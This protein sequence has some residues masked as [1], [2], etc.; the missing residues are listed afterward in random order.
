MQRVQRFGLNGGAREAV[1]DDAPGH[2]RCVAKAVAKDGKD[3]L[4]ADQDSPG[5]HDGLRGF[6]SLGARGHGAS[7]SKIAGGQLN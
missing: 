6:A 2:I 5:F 3:D 1:E 7:R 4:V